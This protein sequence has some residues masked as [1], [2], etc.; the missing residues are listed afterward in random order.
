M[1]KYEKHD[2]LEIVKHDLEPYAFTAKKLGGS[3]AKAALFT[4]QDYCPFVELLQASG[5]VKALEYEHDNQGRL[6]VHGIVLLRRNFHRKRLCKTGFHVKLE[7]IYNEQG[8]IRYIKKSASPSWD[9]KDS[10]AKEFCQFYLF[11]DKS[12]E[13]ADI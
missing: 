8:W 11:G 12:I 5:F 13:T 9:L 10:N 6:H 1:P 4:L 2:E 7:S 3:T